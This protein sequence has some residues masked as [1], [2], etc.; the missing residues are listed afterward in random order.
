MRYNDHTMTDRAFWTRICVEVVCA[1]CLVSAVAWAFA[2]DTYAATVRA[3]A[4]RLQ[5]DAEACQRAVDAPACLERA[6]A[7]SRKAVVLADAARRGTRAAWRE[8]E[9]EIRREDG[10]AAMAETAAR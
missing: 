7:A 1:V 6:Y 2:G 9:L 4:L 10:R 5:A 3:A 8:A